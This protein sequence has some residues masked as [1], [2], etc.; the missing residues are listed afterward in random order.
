MSI[1]QITANSIATSTITAT[2][3]APGAAL[4]TMTSN[5]TY[6]LTTDGTNAL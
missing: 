6:Y 4:P 1:S 5:G 2:K 3:L